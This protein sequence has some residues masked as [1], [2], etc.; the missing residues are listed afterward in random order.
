MK[1]LITDILLPLSLFAIMFAI[2]LSVN[3]CEFLQ[4]FKHKKALVLG[5]SL[6]ILALPLLAFLAIY[7][8]GLKTEYAVAFMIIAASPGGATSNGIT[9]LFSGVVTLS[10]ALTF[11]SSMLMPLTTPLITK[12]S[13]SYFMADSKAYDFPLFKTM[14]Q[15]FVLSVIPIL[16]GNFLQMLAPKKI[17]KIQAKAKKYT[18]LFFIGVL[19]LLLATNYNLLGKIVNQ[20][21]VYLLAMAILALA[22]GF[23]SAK[24]LRLTPNYR[25]TLAIE[26]GL[27]NAG[28][29][30]IITS[31]VLTNETM[32]MILVTYG[33]LMQIPILLFAYFYE[34]YALKTNYLNAK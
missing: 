13:L 33:I 1:E 21:G 11:I 20:L 8:F 9:F 14:A 6:Q 25:L 26:I 10:I 19:L 29:G 31:F 4:V 7:L 5:A 23:F 32:T 18:G 24:S 22:M 28:V 15:L 34:R 16:I 30:I 3:W 17:V 12:W 2:G 27:Q